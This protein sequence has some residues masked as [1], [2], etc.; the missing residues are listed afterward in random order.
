MIWLLCFLLV[1]NLIF[2]YLINGKKLFS[3]TIIVNGVFL[4]SALILLTNWSFFGY[5]D[6]SLKCVII[7]ASSL[8]ALSIGEVVFL[9]FSQQKKV[10]VAVAVDEYIGSSQPKQMKI[11]K[12]LFWISCIVAVYIVVAR[13]ITMYKASLALGNTSGFFG[14][15]Y[16]IRN[17]INKG[18][19][20]DI[21]R[22]ITYPAVF[23]KAVSLYCMLVFCNNRANK[24]K[25]S[26]KL[27]IP[28]VVY[29]IYTALS[30]ARTGIIE[31]VFA[32]CVMFL[33]IYTQNDRDKSQNKKIIKMLLILA[34]VLII[35]FVI[36][37]NIRAGG[38]GVGTS[39]DVINYVGSPLLV[40]NRW[41]ENYEHS[42]FVGYATMPQLFNL[43]NK[44]GVIER[45]ISYGEMY[46][47][48]TVLAS[49]KSNL[50]T[51]LQAPIQ[52][53]TVVGMLITRFF[54]GVLYSFFAYWLTRKSSIKHPGKFIF[55]CLLFYP[56]ISAA[57]ADQFDVYIQLETLYMAIIFIFIGKASK[58]W[59]KKTEKNFII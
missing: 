52:D 20:L 37:G 7:V 12:V 5:E 57:F 40:F 50:K 2:V 18:N 41:L 29:C 10:K 53:F 27:L 35:V 45:E 28:G 6:I 21:G 46:D 32:F 55:A 19:V 58:S 1:V 31:L 36:L 47:A 22:H 49:S 11:S 24:I 8:Y 16:T 56:L 13:A 54:I 39:S 48:E 15:F 14:S 33:A 38:V 17:Y 44:L 23:V 34:L 25:S 9:C 4:M 43:L 26:L 42:P 3:P 30:T 51:W 59:N